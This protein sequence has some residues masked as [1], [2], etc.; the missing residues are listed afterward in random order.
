MKSAVAGISGA[1][2]IQQLTNAG[3][4]A[5]EKHG[6]RED[7]IGQ[8][9]VIYDV[10]P[11]TTT[12]LHLRS[13]FDEH[14]KNVYV[15]KANAKAMHVYVQFPT[16]LV[17]GD[18]AENM[19]HHARRFI[20]GVFGPDSIFADRADR[21]ERGR[22][23]V[24][25]FIAPKYLKRTKHI[26]KIAVGMS[27]HLKDLARKHGHKPNVYGTGRA[28][29]DAFYEYLRDEMG[30]EGV[31]RGIKKQFAGDDHKQAEELR[32][33]E[34][35]KRE[36][37]LI[38]AQN[39]TLEERQAVAELKR[40]VAV[41]L[42]DAGDAK[43]AADHMLMLQE[44]DRKATAA[45]LESVAVKEAEAEQS[46]K[47]A[48]ALASELQAKIEAADQARREWEEN[49]R[50]IGADLVAREL[51]IQRSEADGAARNTEISQS[52]SLIAEQLAKVEFD[53]VAAQVNR[54]EAAK[55]RTMIKT[56]EQRAKEQAEQAE[57]T[58]KQQDHQLAS[59]RYDAERDIAAQ[60]NLEQKQFALLD[61]ASDDRNG[62]QLRLKDDFFAMNDEKMSRDEKVAYESKW[63]Q[64]LVAI[65]RKLASV[66]ERLREMTRTLLL[67]EKQ[68]D[69]KIKLAEQRELNAES[70]ARDQLLG[71]G[72][73]IDDDR[74]KLKI[75]END[76]QQMT[77]Q[78]QRRESA[79]KVTEDEN[80]RWAFIARLVTN[81]PQIFRLATGEPVS[82]T[83]A[84]AKQVEPFVR[85]FLKRDLPD[86]IRKLAEAQIQ[87]RENET[88]ALR[89]DAEVNRA[90]RKLSEIIEK[91]GSELTPSQRE[92][93][94]E[95][96]RAIKQFGAQ[97]G[98]MEM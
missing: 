90:V 32:M 88:Y 35:D 48:E 87:L 28:L 63:P 41:Q 85:E 61:R 18:D 62:L 24:D 47:D 86:W 40:E 65:A 13:L 76:L 91:A 83:E 51:R 69:E 15:P 97:P 67:K 70:R 57:K 55:S 56:L 50:S 92:V 60:R 52:A 37:Q 78:V 33:E 3:I 7:G 36:A 26:E 17:D 71:Q 43:D 75:A 39:S 77:D 95:A 19:V 49:T 21:D 22:T 23:G 58:R 34:L 53:R 29:Q 79:L 4:T 42:A 94:D 98:G 10:P 93:H 59:M 64:A 72:Q 81:Q 20:E 12:G 1:V 96:R 31:K 5:A 54:E 25:V 38:A 11:F 73:A 84:G 74:K 2:R 30:L 8:A 16:E 46:K 44:I 6:K 80:R 82:L 14:I 45:A 27:V 89:R 68:A 9:R 66:L